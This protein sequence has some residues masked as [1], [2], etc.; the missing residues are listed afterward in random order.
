MIIWSGLFYGHGIE[1]THRMKH[2]IAVVHGINQ[3]IEMMDNDVMREAF[4][5]LIDKFG[6][7][8]MEE[9]DI[10]KVE[11]HLKNDKKIR[12]GRLR[13]VV[14]VDIGKVVLHEIE[15]K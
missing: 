7:T 8:L 11:E 13:L 12:D 2:G 3:V 9:I 4:A 14:P 1:K 5:H 15:I 10:K 6:M